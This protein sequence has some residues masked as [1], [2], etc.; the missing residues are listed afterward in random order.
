MATGTMLPVKMKANTVPVVMAASSTR[1]WLPGQAVVKHRPQRGTSPSGDRS[2]PS[3]PR[4][5]GSPVATAT[6]GGASGSGT[7]TVSARV[8]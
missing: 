6:A 1:G 8:G 7:R 4:Q 2:E 5:P 3:S